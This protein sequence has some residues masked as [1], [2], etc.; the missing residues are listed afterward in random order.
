MA[1]KAKDRVRM[2][3]FHQSY[4]YEDFMG[5]FRPVETSAGGAFAFRKGLF[6]RFCDD[7]KK[8]PN[9]KFVFIIDEINRGNLSKIFGE[10]MMLVEPDKRGPDWGIPLTYSKE[11]DAPFYVPDNVYILGLMNTADRSLAM[12]DYALRR[13]FAFWTLRPAFESEKFSEHLV[14][15]EVS[16]GLVKK[17]VNRMTTLNNEIQSDRDLG[18]GFLIGHS[19]FCSPSLP[20]GEVVW[21]EGVIESEIGPLLREYWFDKTDDD[22]KS[23][24]SQLIA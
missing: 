9:K 12:V 17:I 16:A 21:Y 1:E 24:V 22:I 10:I 13:R 19:F 4:S 6:N 14:S 8:F 15:K 11:G 3:Q 5:G 7:A 20:A 23:R 2:V 18:K